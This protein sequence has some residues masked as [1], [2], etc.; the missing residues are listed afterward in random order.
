M[1]KFLSVLFAIFM[2]AGNA[3]AAV[4][5]DVPKNHWAATEIAYCIKEGII[6]PYS[7]NSFRPE[8]PVNR[9]EFNSMLLRALGHL[10]VEIHDKNKFKDLNNNH[11]AYSDILKSE[12]LGLL[13]GYP[14][15]T[16]KPEVQITKAEVA[17]IISHITKQS[18]ENVGI[19]SQF[20]DG[21]KVPSW[22]KNQYAKSIELGIYVNYPEAAYLLPNK[23]LNRAE[24]AVLLYRLRKAMGAVQEK[25]VAKSMNNS[26]NEQLNID[27][28]NSNKNTLS[29]NFRKIVLEGNVLRANISENFGTRRSDIGEFLDFTFVNDVYTEEGA[30]IIPKGSILSSVV[31]SLDSQRTLNKNSKVSVTFNSITFPSGKTAP[32]QGRI[33]DSKGALTASKVA[34]FGKIAGYT[35]GSAAVGVASGIGI[36]AMP[37]PKKVAE[38][39]SDEPNN[40][41]LVTGLVT[42]G[43]TVKAD[44]DASLFVELI[45]DFSIYNDENL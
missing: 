5:T 17:S 10:P 27:D 16:F 45:Q 18:V 23:I 26:A 42:P 15:K 7:D 14:D 11:W 19:L 44:V 21:D 28:N 6:K 29:T 2:L 37:N 38:K 40:A 12:Q 33:F 8:M 1:K 30:L 25:Y 24:A 31:E 20:A 32:V 9:S 39:S 13:Y 22:G 4:I 43:F 3:M 36:S 34:T 35:L 41:E